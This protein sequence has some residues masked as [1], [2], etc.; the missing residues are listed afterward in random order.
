[1]LRKA[2]LSPFNRSC[3]VQIRGSRTKAS[4]LKIIV[5]PQAQHEWQWISY[6]SFRAKLFPSE[7]L[8]D[9]LVKII[10]LITLYIGPK[11]PLNLISF[12]RPACRT[13]L[14]RIVQN[15]PFLESQ[16][17]TSNIFRVNFGYHSGSAFFPY[18]R[19]MVFVLHQK[20]MIAKDARKVGVI[21]FSAQYNLMN[22]PNASRI[23]PGPQK[24][25]GRP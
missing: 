25:G 3:P 15:L 11:V 17:P 2:T 10:V 7:F 16:L 22:F 21:L 1:M 4:P 14:A 23:Y 5:Q 8:T 12:L 13:P 24:L 6:V 19:E 20:W 18:V 9:L